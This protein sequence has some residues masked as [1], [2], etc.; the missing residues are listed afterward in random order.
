M[1]PPDVTRVHKYAPNYMVYTRHTEAK[2]F[3]LKLHISLLLLLSLYI[4]C[5][6]IPLHGNINSNIN[7]SRSVSIKNNHEH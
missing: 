6:K 5:D 1:T 4:W 3:R 7:L 2:E